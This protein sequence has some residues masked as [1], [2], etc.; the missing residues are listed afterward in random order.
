MALDVSRT[1]RIAGA[2]LAAAALISPLL[3]ISHAQ[4]PQRPAIQT[5][6]GGRGP[7]AAPGASDPANANADLSPKPPVL[8]ATPAEQATRFWLPAG[9]RMEPVLADPII[10]DPVQIAFDG[11][12]R[13]FVVEVRGYYQ[14]P[15]GIDLIPPIGRMS[16]HEDR[17]NDGVYERHSV[18]VDK[19]VFPRF[20]TPFG[21]NSHPD[22][23]DQR[24]RSVEVHRHQRA[25]AWPTRR[26]CSRP[27]SG[28]PATWSPSRPACSGRW[29]TGSTAR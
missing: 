25:T 19:M 21:A 27:T 4:T 18:F 29:T 14:T 6:G 23:G 3:L 13:M 17:D 12:G 28:A 1:A 8:A 16:M 24:G 22:D 7:G 2:L 26:S 11:N 5:P 9:Y 20:V 15:E 10:E